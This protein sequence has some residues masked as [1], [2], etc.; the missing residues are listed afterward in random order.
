M[1][2]Q[3]ARMKAEL[4]PT[5]QQA[6]EQALRTPLHSEL[7]TATPWGSWVLWGCS[8]AMTRSRV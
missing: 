2:S 4:P 5:P 8:G 1:H 6:G 7:P 3:E